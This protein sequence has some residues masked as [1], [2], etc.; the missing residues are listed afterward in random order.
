M[1]DTAS[2]RSRPSPAR[3]PSSASGQSRMISGSSNNSSIMNPSKPASSLLQERLRER[4]VESAR[5]ARRGSLDIDTV[6]DAQSSPITESRRPSSSGKGMGVKQIEEHVSSL[7]KQNFN[8][9]LELHHRRERQTELEARLEAAE[10]QLQDQAELQEVNEQ[11]LSELE[12][13]DQAVEEAVGIIVNLEEKI[14]TLMKEREVV[15]NFDAQPKYDPG[16]FRSSHDISSS[17]QTQK[18]NSMAMTRMP[19]FLSEKSEGADALRSLYLPHKESY[20]DAVLPQ[21]QE[22]ALSDAEPESPRMSVLSESSFTSVYGNKTLDLKK[23]EESPLR[24]IMVA[25]AV[26]KWVGERIASP[27]STKP[28][29][30]RSDLR[31]AQLPSITHVIE[32][33]AQRLEKLKHTLEKTSRSATSTRLQ[34]ERAT[35][36]IT[37]I[38]PR[39]ARESLRRVITDK[40]SF[41]HQQRLPPT[42]DTVSTSTLRHFQTNDAAHDTNDNTFLNR[43]PTVPLSRDSFNAYQKALSVRPRSA[44]ETINSRREGHGW[45]T[46]TQDDVSSTCSNFS[47]EEY[48]SPNRTPTPNLFTFGS[49]GATNDRDMD[50]MMFGNGEPRLP[51]LAAS[52]HQTLRRASMVE[53]PRSDDTVR[54]TDYTQYPTTPL[55]SSPRPN[56]PDRRSSLSHTTKLRKS[57]P[58]SSSSSSAG[59]VMQNTTPSP[60]KKKG[61]SRIFGRSETSPS[62]SLP[63]TAYQAAPSNLRS[64]TYPV[65]QQPGNYGEKTDDEARAT[66]PPIMRSRPSGSQVPR[67]RPS[68]AGAGLGEQSVSRRASNYGDAAVDAAT[69][70]NGK[71]PDADQSK[72]KWGVFG[73]SNSQRRT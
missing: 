53:H 38:E 46:E 71:I 60:A 64:P 51:L 21:L 2:R 67:Y 44:G 43:K 48:H 39:K 61:L 17:P 28:S 62:L 49:F 27:V 25:E 42:P 18:S 14:D 59:Q 8:L 73:R 13:R 72:K 15:R 50:Y 37:S 19:S 11:L 55:D 70:D 36:S 4:K 47:A 24:G 12:K 26:E 5:K 40:G 3:P 6:H 68:S 35:T 57:Q 7:T 31:K 29:L 56:P 16:Y 34:M 33:P 41:E 9:K 30:L 10:K 63:A 69:L 22:E 54:A 20:A 58:S 1:D 23:E 45:D 66:P 65:K 52:R 32:S